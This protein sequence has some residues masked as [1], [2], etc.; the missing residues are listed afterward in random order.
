VIFAILTTGLIKVLRVCDR[1]KVI[2][3]LLFNS[4]GME[5]DYPKHHLAPA[6][7]G[8]DGVSPP[9]ESA[10]KVPVCSRVEF[11]LCCSHVPVLFL[12]RIWIL[13]NSVS[14]PL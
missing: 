3:I 4:T 6:V 2:D 14:N 7:V 1:L 5:D 13:L 11:F 9:R 12:I 10:Y 8:E